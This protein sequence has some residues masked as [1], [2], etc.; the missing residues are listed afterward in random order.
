MNYE[1]RTIRHSSIVSRQSNGFS[2]IEMLL[3]MGIL[4]IGLVLVAMVFP[5]GIKLTSIATDRTIGAIAANEAVAKIQLYG[6]R[7]FQYWPLAI[8]A[9]KNNIPAYAPDKWENATYDSCENYI[10]ATNF[11]DWGPDGNPWTADDQKIDLDWPEFLYPSANTPEMR[12]HHWSAL[13]R[14][15][16]EKKVQI[17]VFAT[18]K[19]DDKS[20]HYSYTYDY[21][22][23]KYVH[24][25]D[26]NW[27]MPVPVT[28][29]FS[30]DVGKEKELVVQIGGWAGWGDA[31]FNFFSGNSTIVDNKF[32]RIYRV[33]DYKASGGGVRDTLILTEKW[34]GGDGI[35]WVVPPAVGSDRYPVIAV[36]QTTIIIK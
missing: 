17:T 16:D 11:W 32:G 25:I 4:G 30:N 22:N 15:T 3:A 1:R 12:R 19:V 10:Y 18:R 5:V 24:G 35:I 20:R 26:S 36:R 14:R 29:S 21:I 9:E 33:S 31:P 23:K 13:C 2:L 6:L 34:Q 27:P 7:D 28:I 8:I